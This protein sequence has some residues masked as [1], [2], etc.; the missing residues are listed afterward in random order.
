[1]FQCICPVSEV[2]S[3]PLPRYLGVVTFGAS[4][5]KEPAYGQQRLRE[6]SAVSHQTQW[7]IR[8]RHHPVAEGSGTVTMLQCSGLRPRTPHLQERRT[9]SVWRGSLPVRQLNPVILVTAAAEKLENRVCLRWMQ[10]ISTALKDLIV[11]LITRREE[12]EFSGGQA[13]SRSNGV[14]R[15]S[16][17]CGRRNQFSSCK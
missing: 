13:E 4:G 9:W 7:K 3:N 16:V 1:M 17:G 11:G 12:G 8:N 14:H 2:T 5:L 10:R 6:R 15:Q